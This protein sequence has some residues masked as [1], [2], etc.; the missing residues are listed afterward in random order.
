MNIALTKV[1]ENEIK[2]LISASSRGP[3]LRARNLSKAWPRQPYL[4]KNI[5]FDLYAGEM[6]GV[7]GK[8]GSGKSTLLQLLNGM[9]SIS[10]G[11]ILSHYDAGKLIDITKLKRRAL[12]S[13]RSRCSMIFQ[14][15][16]LV[17]R[18]D[19]LT[20]VMLGRLHHTS[21]LKSLFNLFSEADR[22]RAIS[23]LEWMNML[24]YALQRAEYLSGGQMQRVA[25]CR[26]LMQNPN[27]LLA[28]EPVAA[29]DP[30]N[31]H[32]IMS[33]LCKIAGQGVAVMVNLHSPELVKKY[34]SR[35]IGIAGGQIIFDGPPSGLNA[36]ILH[37]LY[38]EKD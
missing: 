18:L 25:I 32:L 26:A 13:W 7:I 9:Q 36:K 24:P 31:T 5:N 21:T 23:L 27:I 33:A 19:V 34:C 10:G 2:S 35:V 15:Y 6:A 3:V 37:Q 11:E 38:N 16:C 30:A 8:S 20:N 1:S 29:L 28:D 22:S 14:D 17:P 12:T 4:L